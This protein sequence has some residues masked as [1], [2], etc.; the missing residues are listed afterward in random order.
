MTLLRYK[1]TIYPKISQCVCCLHSCIERL[2]E[3]FPL[4]QF[5]ML[6]SNKAS[7]SG[8][9]KLQSST[10]CPINFKHVLLQQDPTDLYE[11]L[12]TSEQISNTN[13][14]WEWRLSKLI[15]LS[16]MD[17]GNDPVN[18]LLCGPVRPHDWEIGWQW[19]NSQTHEYVNQWVD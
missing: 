12:K 8:R 19:L 14:L 2:N 17:S 1:L 3:I 7:M 16:V 9:V 4:S 18:E 11:I 10:P 5:P 13:P 15:S 6:R